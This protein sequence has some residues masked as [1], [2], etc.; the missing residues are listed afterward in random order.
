MDEANHRLQQAATTAQRQ[1]MGRA[2]MTLAHR[3]AI[4]AIKLQFQRQR[5][6]LSHLPHK[7]IVA[8]AD[9]YLAEHR[10]D[11][12]LR[13][14][15]HLTADEVERLIEAA[16]TNRQG[17]RDARMTLLAF[18]HGLRAAEICDLRWEQIDSNSATLHVRRVK[19]GTP[20]THP[21][22][23]RELRAFRRR[24]RESGA[25]GVC[26]RV[27]AWC[28]TECAGLLTHR[29]AGRACREAGDQGSCSYA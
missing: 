28:A 2:V 18:R 12:A 17:H 21:L 25:V 23:G 8:A 14:R 7:V 4:K 27:G 11:A 26:V 5:L 24:Q 6:K 20:A 3:E 13:T 9:E 19:N 15:E 10:A 1:V 22:T 29:R 16:M